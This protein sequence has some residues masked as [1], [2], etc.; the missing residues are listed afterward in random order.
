[1]KIEI[2][3]ASKDKQVILTCELSEVCSIQ[4]AIEQSGILKQFNEIDLRQNP[5]GIFGKKVTLD[6]LLNPNDRVEIY[7]ALLIDPKQARR[8]RAR[9]KPY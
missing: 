9:K 2:A 4:E 3:Y 6:T 8:L 7:R 5:I 1:M